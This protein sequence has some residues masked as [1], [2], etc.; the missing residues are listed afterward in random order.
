VQAAWFHTTVYMLS[1]FTL[2]KFSHHIDPILKFWRVNLRKGGEISEMGSKIM[3]LQ[4]KGAD[5]G[6]EVWS[7]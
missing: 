5:R 3:I 2:F 4:S 7:F 1:S 6:R